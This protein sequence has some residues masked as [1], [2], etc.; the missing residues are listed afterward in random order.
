MERGGTYFKKLFLG[1]DADI[2][3]PFKEKIWGTFGSSQDGLFGVHC[4]DAL[5]DQFGNVGRNTEYFMFF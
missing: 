1:R 2:T 4:R 5:T 3:Y